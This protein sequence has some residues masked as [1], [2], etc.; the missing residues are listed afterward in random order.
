MA[1]PAL[2]RCSVQRVTHSALYRL[3]MVLLMLSGLLAAL[4]LGQRMLWLLRDFQPLG[5]WQEALFLA[6]REGYLALM[7]ALTLAEGLFAAGMLADRA[8]HRM[9]YRLLRLRTRL[10]DAG[11]VLCLACGALLTWLCVRYRVSITVL[12]TVDAV[13]LVLL[14]VQLFRRR[15]YANLARMLA[16]ISKSRQRG[17]FVLGG[18]VQCLLRL[19]CLVLC[20]AAA[21][22]VALVMLQGAA[23][24]WLLNFLQPL[25]GATLT[26][27]LR[28]MLNS[29]VTGAFSMYGVE[30]LASLL[31][32]GALLAVAGVY[33]IYERA[34]E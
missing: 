2:A 29:G 8:G 31:R 19:Q 18:G 6:V 34:H 27:Q 9:M 23:V 28:G 25:L 4:Q 20:A 5:L 13:M 17:S 10:T 3:L 24:A 32:M 7:A 11:L 14:L 1:R 16:D 15:L 22:P 33:G 21:I 26:D 12:G 30:V